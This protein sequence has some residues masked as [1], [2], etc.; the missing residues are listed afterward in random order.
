MRK[1]LFIT[2]LSCIIFTNSFAQTSVWKVT[3][4]KGNT[5]YI[6][7]TVHLLSPKDYPLP[8][9]FNIAYNDSELL[10]IEADIDQL[11]NPAIAQKM[12]GKIM[13]QD[14]R[15]LSTVLNKP[16]YEM[17]K[18]ECAKFNLPL[19]N[20]DK[21]KPSMVIVTLTGMKMKT[22]GITSEGVD[23]HFLDKAKK[24]KKGVLF[25]ESVDSQL[26]LLATMG[27][28]NEN[29]FVK[30]S[31]NELSETETLMDG[32]ISDW[33]KGEK[34]VM[35]KQIKEMK[36]DY[37]KL[38]KDLLVNRNNN[39]MPVI[40]N[41]LSTKKTELVLMGAL[42]LHGKDG[43]LNLLKKKGYKLKQL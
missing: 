6:G 3:N 36:R 2:L 14:E 39:W 8:K 7:G 10:A 16:V 1:T 5:I 4:K 25:L 33:R 19:A 11:E 41:Y 24:D 15:T 31:L 35:G 13:Y 32:L 42:H 20:L 37:P 38:H 9:E 26:N 23:K 22:S 18:K 40:D 30:K 29:N 21:L 28:G 12:M 34:K 17:L 27:D 43:I